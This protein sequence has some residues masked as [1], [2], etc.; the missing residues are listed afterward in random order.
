MFGVTPIAASG[1]TMGSVKRVETLCGTS[2]NDGKL[3]PSRAVAVSHESTGTGARAA[4]ASVPLHSTEARGAAPMAAPLRMFAW[5]R[6][7]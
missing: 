7:E 5:S 6:Y 2:V 3:S 4:S 1:E